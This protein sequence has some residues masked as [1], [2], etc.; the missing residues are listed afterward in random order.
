MKENEIKILNYILQNCEMG[1][2]TSAV[3]LERIKDSKLASKIREQNDTY[4]SILDKVRG[5]IASKDGSFKSVG[6]MQ[7][8]M[9]DMMIKMKTAMDDTSSNIA[10]MIIQGTNMGI[11]E[12]TKIINS[13]DLEDKEIRSLVEELLKFENKRLEEMKAFL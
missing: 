11:M 6:G 3:L 5:L 4:N 1:A 2:E 9:A 7:K 12:L 8:Y 10:E 13:N